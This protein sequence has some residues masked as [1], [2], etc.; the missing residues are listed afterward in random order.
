MSS[1]LAPHRTCLQCR[2]PRRH[3]VPPTATYTLRH[4]IYTT[5]VNNGTGVACQASYGEPRRL[6]RSGAL[7]RR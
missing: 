2:R 1:L 7:L 6:W 3:R 5:P 4:Q